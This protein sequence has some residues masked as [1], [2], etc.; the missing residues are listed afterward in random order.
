MCPNITEVGERPMAVV[1]VGSIDETASLR[2]LQ[3]EK[4][5]AKGIYNIFP[6]RPFIPQVCT[7]L[8]VDSLYFA[9]IC[10]T[11]ALYLMMAVD[12]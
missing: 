10:E 4:R 9:G 11:G 1:H 6:K 12:N 8:Y 3:S 2:P 5:N 7:S